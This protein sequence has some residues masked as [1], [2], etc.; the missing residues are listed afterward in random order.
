MCKM[1]SAKDG[2]PNRLQELVRRITLREGDV[3]GS[4]AELGK[5]VAAD[6]SLSARDYRDV[7]TPFLACEQDPD[8]IGLALKVL[9]LWWRMAGEFR[10]E[11]LGYMDK[12]WEGAGDVRQT[13][14]S[15]A[16]ECLRQTSD[17]EILHAL[18]RIIDTEEREW[19][20]AAFRS[21]LDAI[22]RD[23]QESPYDF[24]Y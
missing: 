12:R 6:S 9:C 13:A 20:Q 10:E 23:S 8:L 21:V 19:R 11:I 15:C 17:R 3:Y 16:G 22:G 4:I 1:D 14:V 7:I 18:N 5:T 24:K 2:G